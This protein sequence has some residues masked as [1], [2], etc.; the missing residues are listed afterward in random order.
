METIALAGN[1]NSGKTTLFNA[2]TGSTAK[3]GNYPGITVSLKS[4]ELFTPHGR[5]LRVV[6][7][8]GCY[9]LRAGSRDEQVARQFLAGDDGARPDLVVCVVD[10][11]NLERH[12][13][14]TLQVIELGLPVVIALNMVDLAEEAGLRLDPQK[15]SEELG[16]PVVPMQAN[17]DKGIVELKQAIQHPLP[18]AAEAHWFK[19]QDE[20][21]GDSARRELIRFIC[22][23]SARRPADSQLTRSDKIDAELLHP[24]RGWIYFLASMF[25]VFWAIFSFAEIPMTIIENAQGWLQEGIGSLIPEGDFR[26]LI[27]DGIIGGVGSVVVFLPQIVLL[28]LFIGLLESSGYMARAAY[29]MDGVMA[30]AGLSG[31]IV[32]AAVQLVRLRHSRRHG[33]ADDRLGQGAHGD[34]FHRPV[35][36]L[37]GA[38]AGL[39]PARAAVAGTRGGSLGAGAGAVRDLR[40]RHRHRFHRRQTSAEKTRS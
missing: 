18:L 28:F 34:Y 29:L 21:G 31:E 3:T 23:G 19:D 15:M 26:S 5:K 4:G 20:D 10:A 36:E 13:N 6:D 35:D 40:H 7:L 38:P 12:L 11:S 33:G 32:P 22:E 14:L 1:P 37:R 30:K 24:V 39:F 16:V 27:V 25:A 9:S 8:P 2:L 17:A